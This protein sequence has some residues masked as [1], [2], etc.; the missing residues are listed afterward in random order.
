MRG[1]CHKIMRPWWSIT[2]AGSSNSPNCT[3]G[4]PSYPT[5]SN[6]I[7]VWW[8]LL[9]VRISWREVRT[10]CF[11]PRAVWSNGP[12]PGLSQTM[13]QWVGTC[14]VTWDHWYIWGTAHVPG[15]FRGVWGL[16]KMFQGC[17]SEHF[18]LCGWPQWSDINGFWLCIKALLSTG[19]SEVGIM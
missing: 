1:R 14:V 16:Y 12:G 18:F 17:F 19:W 5:V 7:L 9:T 8:F 13:E 3:S 6:N 15:L 2:V 11:C 4:Y 10:I